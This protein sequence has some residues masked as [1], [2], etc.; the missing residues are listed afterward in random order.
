MSSEAELYAR[1]FPFIL[2]DFMTKEDVSALLLYNFIQNKMLFFDI[3]TEL[4][5]DRA[6]Y[7]KSLIE[8]GEDLSEKI[9][10]IIEL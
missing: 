2:R 6:N 5:I 8:N 10:P 4:G 7:Y 1:L 3:N 9:K